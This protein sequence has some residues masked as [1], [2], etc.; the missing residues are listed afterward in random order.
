MGYHVIVLP[1]FKYL[2]TAKSPLPSLS[3]KLD[4]TLHNPHLPFPATQL[5][6]KPSQNAAVASPCSSQTIIRALSQLVV[7]PNSKNHLTSSRLRYAFARFLH[8]CSL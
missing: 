4:W 5:T 8:F 3:Q 6:P 1:L 2:Q 7:A